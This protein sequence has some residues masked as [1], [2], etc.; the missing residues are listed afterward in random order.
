M[1][2]SRM[3]RI[4]S[5]IIW[6]CRPRTTLQRGSR[7]G[8]VI[9]VFDKTK[10]RLSNSSWSRTGA[11]RR[12]KISK[13]NADWDSRRPRPFA[14]GSF[15]P[16]TTRWRTWIPGKSG[17]SR[18]IDLRTGADEPTS[19]LEIDEQALVEKLIAHA[20]GANAL[21]A[22]VDFYHRFDIFLFTS[23]LDKF[24]NFLLSPTGIIKMW[25]F[26]AFHDQAPRN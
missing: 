7:R 5:T 26:F 25:R 6:R 9:I 4:S 15:I 20:L 2:S 23:Q 18:A 19:L 8:G 11:R 1:T 22:L 16:I 13:C 10:D 24:K 14:G 21:F 3:P 12:R 17:T